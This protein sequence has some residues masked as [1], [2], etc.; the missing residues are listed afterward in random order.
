MAEN[1]TL[2]SLKIETNLSDL[3]RTLQQINNTIKS[4]LKA[5]VDLTFNIR[6]EKRIEALKQRI[7]KEIKIPVSFQKKGKAS[8]PQSPASNIPAQ[9]HTSSGIKGIVSNLNNTQNQISTIVSGGVLVGFSKG[10]AESIRK[11]GSQFENLK[12]MLEN[13][14]GGVAEG[15]SAMKMIKETADFLRR[16]I[17]E[18]GN[19]FNKLI[20]RGLKP[21]KEEFIK[22]SDVAK[23]Q[24]KSIDQYVE[25]V[26]DAM[27]GENERLK[28]FGI[29]A[30]DAGDSWIYTFKGVSTQVKKNETDIYNYMTSLGLLPGVM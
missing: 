7:S 16:P 2:V 23:S 13:S 14:L 3:K 30:K 10:L 20:N 4:S 11:A 8:A 5:Q 17:D 26:L 21:T 27:T 19:G 28:E 29:K 25:A 18:V 6:G 22:L 12:A 9:I 1:E 15:S 24:G